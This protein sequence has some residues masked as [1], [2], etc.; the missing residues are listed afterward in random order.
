[1]T[2]RDPFVPFVRAREGHGEEKRRRPSTASSCATMLVQH[3]LAPLRR[4]SRR[5][6]PPPSVHGAWSPGGRQAGPPGCHAPTG[7]S[8]VSPEVPE[9]SCGLL[10]LWRLPTL[11]CRSGVAPAQ[12]QDGDRG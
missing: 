2:L 1:M 10:L 5:L 8:G 7:A 3:G 4:S 12:G 9:R 11:A 6:S